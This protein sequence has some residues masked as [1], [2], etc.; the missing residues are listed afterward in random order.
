MSLNTKVVEDY[1]RN[2][3]KEDMVQDNLSMKE[4]INP[5]KGYARKSLDTVVSFHKP[6]EGLVKYRPL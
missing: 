2:Q 5:F 3:E 6:L 4:H 1:T